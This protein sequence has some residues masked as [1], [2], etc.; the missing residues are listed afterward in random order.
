MDERTISKDL[1]ALRPAV[2]VYALIFGAKL[3]AY[4]M[5]GVLALLAEALHTLSDVFISGFLWIAVATLIAWNAIALLRENASFLLGRSPGPE[6]RQRV[7]Y[8]GP[9]TVYAG[10]IVELAPELTVLEADRIAN[11]VDHRAHDEAHPGYC[12]V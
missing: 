8:L 7:E 9:D 11:K 12:F 1:D 5:T 6:F 10:M 2:V 3:G 4:L